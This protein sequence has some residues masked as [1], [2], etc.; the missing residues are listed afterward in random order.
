MSSGRVEEDSKRQGRVSLNKN[1]KGKTTKTLFLRVFVIF[2]A[3]K[4]YVFL[5]SVGQICSWIAASVSLCLPGCW[6]LVL[7]EQKEAGW[8]L[9]SPRVTRWRC[10]VGSH[11]TQLHSKGSSLLP[12]PCRW[13]KKSFQHNGQSRWEE[14]LFASVV[15]PVSWMIKVTWNKGPFCPLKLCLQ[16]GL[17]PWFPC[18]A[19]RG[20]AGFLYESNKGSTVAKLTQTEF[21]V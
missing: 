11:S 18:A 12:R 8:P 3:F 15:W 13:S 9:V 10:M 2:W 7:G 19:A 5:D 16:C 1:K 17:C 20:F 4:K 21:V 14:L 6:F